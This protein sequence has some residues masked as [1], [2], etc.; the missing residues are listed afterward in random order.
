ML[1]PHFIFSTM[2]LLG[3]DIALGTCTV[4]YAIGAIGIFKPDFM[5][6]CYPLFWLFSMLI[7]IGWGLLVVSGI[8][9]CMVSS[10]VY[11]SNIHDWPFYLKIVLTIVA[12]INGLF[13]SFVVTP[14]GEKAVELK[15]FATTNEYLKVTVM[16]IIG[17]I[18]SFT[19]WY[20]AFALA[21][22]A[23]RTLG[24]AVN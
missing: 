12:A 4:T 1:S 19:C 20:G 17:G 9:L 3:L 11:G 8:G 14:L 24:G 15:N 16:G 18:I 7:W 2:H 21:I 23:F 6:R 10:D 5:K 13:L 22:F